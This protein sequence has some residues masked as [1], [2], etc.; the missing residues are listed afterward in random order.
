MFDKKFIR[1]AIDRRAQS[2]LD[3]RR[4]FSAAGIAGLGV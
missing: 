2:P 4:F 1:Q 3:R